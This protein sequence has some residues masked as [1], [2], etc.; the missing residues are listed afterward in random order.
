MDIDISVTPQC[1][2]FNKQFQN[3][4][5]AQTRELWSQ[6]NFTPRLCNFSTFFF[7]L[8][9]FVCHFEFLTVLNC[10]I[11]SLVRVNV[12]LEY[13]TKVKAFVKNDKRETPAVKTD[14]SIFL[15]RYSPDLTEV[16]Q[17]HRKKCSLCPFSTTSQIFCST[18]VKSPAQMQFHQI[19]CPQRS[20]QYSHSTCSRDIR[21]GPG[22]DLLDLKSIDCT[23][24]CE[25]HSGE[26]AN[27]TQPILRSSTVYGARAQ[28]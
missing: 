13:L 25:Y 24:F 20:Q 15:S 22:R 17:T 8:I 7:F 2:L 26:A 11:L 10:Y 4:T 18:I 14:K 9:H 12:I 23:W 1:S 21:S 28:E 5:Y 16:I 19:T 27:G 6:I 3:S